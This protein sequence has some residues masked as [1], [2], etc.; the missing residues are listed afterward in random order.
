MSTVLT[1]GSVVIRSAGKSSEKTQPQVFTTPLFDSTL[2]PRY[3]SF[4]QYCKIRELRKDPTIQLARW[5]VLS[6]MIHTPWVYVSP[7]DDASKEMLQFVEDVLLLLREDLL[8]RAVF[9]TLDYGWTPFEVVYK[10]DDGQLVIDNFKGLLHDFTYILAYVDTG[11]FAGFLNQSF[12]SV[13]YT[14]IDADYS[15]NTNFEVEGTDWYGESV[16]NYTQP[17]QNAWNDAQTTANRYDKKVA[18]AT[19]AVYYPVGQTKH[20]GIV[21]DNDVIAKAILTSLE[22]SGGV[23]IPDEIQEWLDDS[24][25]KET[26]GKWRIEL[27]TA[28]GSST[29]DFVDRLKYLDVLKIRAF[30]LTERSL[31]EGSHGT[32]AEAD[33]HGDVALSIVDSRH[34]LLCNQ[35]NKFVIPRL[36]ELNYGKK[37]KY[38]VMVRPAPLVDTQFATI[39]EIY[40]A[41]LQNPEIAFAELENLNL[42][43]L[44]EEIGIPSSVIGDDGDGKLKIERKEDKE[45]S[46][47]T[48][49]KKESSNG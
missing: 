49:S 32:K 13:G 9:G 23:A 37:Y 47:D 11:G 35:L 28:K 12:N 6:P 10:E 1:P 42:R 27:M 4:L 29:S 44:R 45:D 30:A 2:Y 7:K 25:D 26:R 18:G 8:M 20:N 24:I 38:S 31:L 16:Y 5:A 14:V 15:F 19:W 46:K 17:I 48:D 43:A 34:R 3:N 36:M 22:A 41:L 21:K 40:R 33:V 39:K